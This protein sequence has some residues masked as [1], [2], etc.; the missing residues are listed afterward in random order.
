MQLIAFCCLKALHENRHLK[1]ELQG[2]RKR[3]KIAMDALSWNGA[4]QALQTLLPP[5]PLPQQSSLQLPVQPMAQPP[6]PLASAGGL[7]CLS[8]QG[9][10][11]VPTRSP[12][13]GNAASAVVRHLPLVQS[14]SGT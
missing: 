5:G 6:A 10:Y 4:P 13:S 11:R 3:R 9:W 7:L 8:A 14:P 2:E 1:E 12:V